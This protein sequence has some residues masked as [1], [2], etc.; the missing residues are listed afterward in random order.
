MEH[1]RQHDRN[2]FLEGDHGLVYK[3]P[4]RRKGVSC[5]SEQLFDAQGN[6]SPEVMTFR[7]SQKVDAEHFVKFYAKG[8]DMVADL[9][10]C[11]FKVCTAIL[12]TYRD[13]DQNWS[14]VVHCT[15]KV[16]QRHNYPHGESAWFRGIDELLRKDV[17]QNNSRGPG[18]YFLNPTMFYKGDR[19]ALVSEYIGRPIR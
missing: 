3:L 18:I 8:I 13:D 11:A 15:H 2:P 16:A 5:G 14:D 12:A 9:S 6:P 4:T 7:R 17:I 19:V 10:R 1:K